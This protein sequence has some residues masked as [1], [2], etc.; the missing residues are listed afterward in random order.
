MILFIFIYFFNLFLFAH[1]KSQYQDCD[2]TYL[3]HGKWRYNN[4]TH[5]YQQF[6]ANA[7]MKFTMLQYFLIHFLILKEHLFLL[8][9]LERNPNATISRYRSRHMLVLS[10]SKTYQPIYNLNNDLREPQIQ[11]N[12]HDLISKQ[13]KM[14]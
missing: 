10:Y 8:F 4:S 9:Y 13:L 14:I 11:F 6:L 3:L 1:N 7:C 2:Y 5:L 12:F